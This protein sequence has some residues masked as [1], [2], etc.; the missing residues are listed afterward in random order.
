MTP[1]QIAV[2]R[3]MIKKLELSNSRTIEL[4]EELESICQD[5]HENN[6][7]TNKKLFK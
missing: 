3:E 5:L 6:F 2:F 1:E 7:Q 4:L